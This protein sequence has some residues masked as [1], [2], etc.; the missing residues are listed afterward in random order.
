MDATTRL[1]YWRYVLTRALF[2]CFQK[3]I[4]LG[5]AIIIAMIIVAYQQLHHVTVDHDGWWA[6][7][8]P[9]LTELAA[10]FVLQ[11]SESCYKFHTS[12]TKYIS[13][14][15]LGDLLLR[16]DGLAEDFNMSTTDGPGFWSK[17]VH[18]W[19][20]TV[21]RLLEE[22]YGKP[23]NDRFRDMRD[24]VRT[25]D[26]QITDQERLRCLRKN[27]STLLVDFDKK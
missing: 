24:A 11:V 7:M 15:R 26:Q 19:E 20:Q 21:S 3:G 17:H 9:Y 1:G 2:A 4:A 14:N 16:G 27:L 5:F 6:V 18:L 25:N 13:R 22:N 12:I 23:S 8:K 10:W